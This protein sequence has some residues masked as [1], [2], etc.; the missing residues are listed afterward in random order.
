MSKRPELG[1]LAIDPQRVPD[2]PCWVID[3][4]ALE[5]NLQILAAVQRD[6]DCKVL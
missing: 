3:L 5:Q 6:A 2:S 4:P 1:M